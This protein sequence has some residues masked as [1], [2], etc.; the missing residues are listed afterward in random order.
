LL[1]R[2]TKYYYSDTKNYEIVWLVQVPCRCRCRLYALQ[3]CQRSCR[4]C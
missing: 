4:Y 2:R 1:A 3:M